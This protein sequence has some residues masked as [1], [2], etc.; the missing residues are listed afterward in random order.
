MNPKTVQAGRVFVELLALI[1]TSVV[2]NMWVYCSSLK[3]PCFAHRGS[4]SRGPSYIGGSSSCMPRPERPKL[5]TNLVVT[6]FRGLVC[7]PVT[8]PI[9]C[10]V[11]TSCRLQSS[12]NHVQ[13]GWNAENAGNLRSPRCIPAGPICSHIRLG[14]YWS[15]DRHST[16]GTMWYSCWTF[17]PL[18]W[19][20]L[21]L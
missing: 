11:W 3:I 12:A 15:R 21:R 4:Y 13:C 16:Q 6:A 2:H 8:R 7:R 20:T 9:C 1:W 17:V 18:I 5:A 19:G 14:S 10:S